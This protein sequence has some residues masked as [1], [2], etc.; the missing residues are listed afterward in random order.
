[1][2]ENQFSNLLLDEHPLL[3]MPSLAITVGLN[4]AI[5]LQQLHYWLVKNKGKPEMFKGGRYWCFCSLDQ[6]KEQF[7]FWSRSTL[8]RTIASLETKEIVITGNFN[9]RGFDKTLWYSIDYEA[10]EKVKISNLNTSYVQIEQMECS[11]WADASVQIEQ[12]N[13]RDLQD[14]YTINYK[15]IVENFNR[16][17]V[18]FPRLTKISETR[19]KAI[20]ARFNQ[21]YTVEDFNR[22][23][24]AAESSDFLKGKNA[25]NWSAT[26]DWLISDSNM[27]KVLDGN[28]VNRKQ[29]AASMIGGMS[30][31]ERA[32]RAVYGNI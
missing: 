12:T 19:K 15:K 8:R 30:D 20:R 3:V 11:D 2:S 26:F 27:A 10:L 28:Y 18:S 31:A 25:R 23:F 16:T 29:V 24:Q 4:E 1:M 32:Q 7:P 22:L 6:W 17:C 5:F 21:G 9:K 13:T 14:N